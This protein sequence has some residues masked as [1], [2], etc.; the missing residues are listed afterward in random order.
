M[1]YLV[2]VGTLDTERSD[3]LILPVLLDGKWTP[4]GQ[5]LDKISDRYLSK[6]LKTGD[7]TGKFKQTLLLHDVPG[8]KAKRVLLI[9]CGKESELTEA[10]YQELVCLAINTLKQTAAQEVCCLLPELA[11][12]KRTQIW[13]IRQA[14]I[15]AAATMYQFND[16]RSKKNQ[17][18]KTLTGLTFLVDKAELAASKNAV[19]EGTAISRAMDFAKN[20]ENMPANICNPKYIAATATKWAK[21]QKKVKCTVLGEKAMEKLGMGALLAVG[22]GSEN[23]SQLIV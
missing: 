1:D 13:N 18:E 22:R 20:L 9:G 4:S 23:E 3:A 16:F 10:K 12:K 5:H 2:K 6:I 11:Y 19:N 21:S 8:I 15:S 14:I 7:M 17:A